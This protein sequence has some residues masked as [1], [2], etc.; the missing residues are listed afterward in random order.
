MF[1]YNNAKI[2]LENLKFHTSDFSL[3]IKL[4]FELVILG[5]II[6]IFAEIFKYAVELR[7]ENDLTI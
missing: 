2:I 6:I 4:N 3:N 7:E 5:I 1:N